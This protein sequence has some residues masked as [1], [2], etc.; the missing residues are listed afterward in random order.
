MC[1]AFRIIIIIIISCDAR[2]HKGARMYVVDGLLVLLDTSESSGFSLI[3][4]LIVVRILIIEI[5]SSSSLTPFRTHH[6]RSVL[7]S[8][9]IPLLSLIIVPVIIILPGFV[10]IAIKSII[11]STIVLNVA[12]RVSYCRLISRIMFVLLS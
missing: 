6:Q 10:S 9:S 7:S 12:I 8:L 11:T 5:A 2:H 3:I 1:I 4:I